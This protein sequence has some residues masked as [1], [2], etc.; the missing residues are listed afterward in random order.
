MNKKMKATNILILLLLSAVTSA[1]SQCPSPTYQIGSYCCFDFNKTYAVDMIK[2]T[3]NC[4]QP[5]K[6]IEKTCCIRPREIT[7][8][9]TSSIDDNGRSIISIRSPYDDSTMRTEQ[10]LNINYD[11]I[12]PPLLS[13]EIPTQTTIPQPSNFEIDPEILNMIGI[14]I[15]AIICVIIWI[16]RGK[17]E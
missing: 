10:T 13:S 7:L 11:Q 6:S 5:Y 14:I 4:T 8:K 15:F 9:Y 16:F 12:A 17:D 2:L 1:Q 3:N